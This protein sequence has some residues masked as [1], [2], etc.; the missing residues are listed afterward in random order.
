MAWQVVVYRWEMIA[1]AVAVSRLYLV[2]R[3]LVDAFVAELPD[4]KLSISTLSGIKFDANFCIKKI[5]TSWKAFKIIFAL[6]IATIVTGMCAVL[7][8]VLVCVC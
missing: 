3:T 1:C 6:W 7:A 4:S 5:L 8:S 2:T